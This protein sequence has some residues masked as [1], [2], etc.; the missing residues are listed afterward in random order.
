MPASPIRVGR[1]GAL[2]MARSASALHA[3]V[4]MWFRRRYA[5]H[6]ETWYCVPTRG[7]LDTSIGQMCAHCRLYV[8]KYA[9]IRHSALIASVV[10]RKS[11][12]CSVRLN[13]LLLFLKPDPTFM[14]SCCIPTRPYLNFS[15]AWM[16]SHGPLQVGDNTRLAHEPPIGKVAGKVRQCS[17]CACPFVLNY[18]AFRSSDR[19]LN[20][21]TR[22]FEC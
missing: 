11:L 22:S 16:C 21:H 2:L 14:P 12:K 17:V 18:S 6:K 10:H 8:R 3:H 5:P 13:R 19:P 9:C 1:F 20:T 15:I 7:N 4:I